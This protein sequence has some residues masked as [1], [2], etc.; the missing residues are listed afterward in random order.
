M[1]RDLAAH[2][3]NFDAIRS[4]TPRALEAVS[5]IGPKMS[6]AITAFFADERNAAAIDADPR[7]RRASRRRPSRRRRRAPAADAGAAV[8]TGAIP[9]PGPRRRRSGG[10]SVDAWWAR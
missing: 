2:F 10:A 4:G 3:G 7:P 8:F 1:A 9:I 6:A 5:G